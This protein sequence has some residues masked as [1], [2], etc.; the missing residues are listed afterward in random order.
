MSK[1]APIGLSAYSRINHLKKTVEALKKNTLAKK[2][3]LFIFSDAPKKGDEEKVGIVRDYIHNVGGFRK[4]HIIERKEN[5]SAFNGRDGMRQLLEKYGKI[6]FMEEDNVSHPMFLKYMNEALD[7]FYYDKKIVAI[8]GYCVPVKFRADY[9]RSF[10]VS[11]YFGVPF[12]TWSDRGFMGAIESKGQYLEMKKNK[13]LRKRIKKTTPQLIHALKSMHE[14][15][16]DA[17][18]YKINFFMRKNNLY[19][20]SPVR[21]LI[22]NIGHDGTGEHCGINK[23]LKID[24]TLAKKVEFDGDYEYDE[25]MD[26]EIYKYKKLWWNF[27][28][29]HCKRI[30]WKTLRILRIF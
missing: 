28:L 19:C 14:G 4:V 26:R 11:V 3:E 22:D 1:L 18:D 23:K 2:S 21:S 15:K 30:L 16:L 6:I 8:R 13:K 5:N 17:G 12:A 20:V 29:R 24:L 10:F 25:K 9:S 7:F 27:Y